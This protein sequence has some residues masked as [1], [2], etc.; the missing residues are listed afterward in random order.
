MH[1]KLLSL[2]LLPPMNQKL[3]NVPI[4]YAL[5]RKNLKSD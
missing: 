3:E 2:T 4:F 5:H 1:F